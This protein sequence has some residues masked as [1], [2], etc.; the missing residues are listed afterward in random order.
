[1]FIIQFTKTNSFLF[2][3]FNHIQTYSLNN[4]HQ[5]AASENKR[6]RHNL[7]KDDMNINR[8][9]SQLSISQENVKKK[10]TTTTTTTQSSN[11]ILTV[12]NG[13]NQEENNESLFMNHVQ[14]FKPSYL[15]VSD[16]IFKVF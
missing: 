2:L 13:D 3:L 8:S 1:M 7:N 6:K 16:E 15:K 11:Q 12:A 5:T 10:K 14:K 4:Q 9:F